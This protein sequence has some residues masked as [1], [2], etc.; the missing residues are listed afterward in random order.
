MNLMRRDYDQ[1]I[2]KLCPCR[3]Y[4][5]LENIQQPY[6][7]RLYNNGDKMVN[8]IRRIS[9][10]PIFITTFQ[11]GK[12]HAYLLVIAKIKSSQKAM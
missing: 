8:P 3:V 10:K 12:R 1:Q 5:S 11:F 4:A 7:K 6:T 9:K 2:P